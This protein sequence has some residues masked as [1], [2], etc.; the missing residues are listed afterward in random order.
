MFYIGSL[1]RIEEQALKRC[2]IVLIFLF[3]T[4]TATVGSYQAIS[5][6][7][8]IQTIERGSSSRTNSH[9]PGIT[10]TLSQNKITI[11]RG[12]PARVD[13]RIS[14]APSSEFRVTLSAQPI[15]FGVS[16]SFS[17]TSAK[18]SFVSTMTII[19]NNESS[20]GHFDLTVVASGDGVTKVASLS[21]LE[22]A[23]VHDLAVIGAIAPTTATIG[24]I[25]IVNATVANYGSFPE[26]YTLNLY[27][28]NTQVATESSTALPSYAEKLASL[29]W[30]STGFSAGEYSLVVAVLP[31]LGELDIVDNHFQAGSIRLVQPPTG[32]PSPPTPSPGSPQPAALNWRELAIAIAI[33]WIVVVALVF[34]RGTLRR[35]A[36]RMRP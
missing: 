14:L 22:A 32:N 8:P 1:K 35:A 7:L 6:S 15:P 21:I 33:A 2:A 29:S 12:S 18:S 20:L 34:F 24:K 9:N 27:A 19:A 26:N 13:V 4:T 25:V 23:L 30:N 16:V 11:V 31:V 17:P 36:H 5:S 3:V 10:L 28:N